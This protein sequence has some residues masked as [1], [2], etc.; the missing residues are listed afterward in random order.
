[1]SASK[2]RLAEL[3]LELQVLSWADVVQ[4]AV[5]LGMKFSNLKKIEDEKNPVLTAMDKWLETDNQASWEKVVKALRDINK[6]V[7]SQALERKYCSSPKKQPNMPAPLPFVPLIFAANEKQP[8]ES[9]PVLQRS[10]SAP[11][12]KFFSCSKANNFYLQ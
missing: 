1:M 4:M 2:P 8:V 5:Q 7:L 9:K 3:A 12:S 10:H 6:N 11:I